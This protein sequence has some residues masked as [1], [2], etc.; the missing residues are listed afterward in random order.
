M[1][2]RAAQVVLGEGAA[3]RQ[4]APSV[5]LAFEEH[6]HT[7]ALLSLGGRYREPREVAGDARG[8]NIT[9]ETTTRVLDLTA[10]CVDNE[11]GIARTKE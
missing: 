9:A 6:A 3:G 4:E 7:I 2:Y 5:T 11:I 10:R 8:G 1:A